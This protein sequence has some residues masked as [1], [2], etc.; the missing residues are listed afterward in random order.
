MQARN[1]CADDIQEKQPEIQCQAD[2]WVL[3]VCPTERAV[4]K[5]GG[6]KHGHDKRYS[7]L[8]CERGH[9]VIPV[10]VFLLS[11]MNMPH[12]NPCRCAILSHEDD[13]VRILV[14]AFLLSLMTKTT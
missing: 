12:D 2:A 6:T 13:H 14:I 4:Q 9:D 7:L 11:L 3:G 1:F 8:P 10:V 5:S